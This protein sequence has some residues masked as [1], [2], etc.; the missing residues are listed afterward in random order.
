MSTIPKRSALIQITRRHSNRKVAR[1]AVGVIT[2]GKVIVIR[3]LPGIFARSRCRQ[4]IG[5]AQRAAA[6][7]AILHRQTR[8][9][10]TGSL[11]RN[12][13][14]AEQVAAALIFAALCRKQ[15]HRRSAQHIVGQSIFVGVRLRCGQH[16]HLA[17]HA[18]FAAVGIIYA[19]GYG[20]HI[21][22]VSREAVC[23]LCHGLHQESLCLIVSDWVTDPLIPEHFLLPRFRVFLIGKDLISVGNKEN[24]RSYGKAP[25]KDT[26]CVEWVVLSPRVGGTKP[27]YHVQRAG[28]VGFCGN[29]FPQ[30]D[31]GIDT[32]GQV[33]VD[34]N[35]GIIGKLQG[36]QNGCPIAFLKLR[37][38][39][40]LH[41]GRTAALE[42]GIN[43]QADRRDGHKQI[44]C[45][46]ALRRKRCTK[47]NISG[48]VTRSPIPLPCYAAINAECRVPIAHDCS[49]FGEI[50]N[51]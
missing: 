9:C 37:T 31:T 4:H 5:L 14:N 8:C 17:G 45:C 50:I 30:A 26:L 49:R 38:C 22:A 29:D 1:A 47:C 6:G 43:R 24:P 28:K 18:D 15:L 3:Q 12:R 7:S 25:V 10:L 40:S 21:G 2:D 34:R 36:S 39:N 48:P 41:F 35:A 23:I 42:T 19:F 11:I 33:Y 44:E 32:G 51:L 20:I 16:S 27:K 46:R 13:S